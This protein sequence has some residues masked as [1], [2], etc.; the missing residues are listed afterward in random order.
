MPWSETTKMRERMRFVVDAEGDLYTMTELCE[1]YGISRMT[2]HKWLRRFRQDGVGGLEDRSRAPENCPHRTDAEVV[3]ALVDA[4]HRHPNWGARKLILWVAKRQPGLRLPAAS[5]AG[6]ILKRLGLVKDR[7]RRRHLPHPGRPI[8]EGC[9]PNQLWSADFKG[10]FKTRDGVYCYPLT[11]TDSFSRYL[12]GCQSQLSTATIPTKKNFERVFRTYGLPD[13]IRTDNGTPFSAATAISRLS[14]LSVWWIRLGIRPE[15][16]QPSHP[17]QNGRHERM[18]RTLK[19][20]TTRP[21]AANARAQQRVFDSFR[22]EFNSERPHERLAN[23]TPASLYQPSARPYP[24]RL[25]PLEYPGHF[26][27]RR[28]SR[29]GGIRW[30]KGWVNISTSI[31]EENVG[32]E[33]VDDGVWS[34]YFGSLLLG[35]FHEDDLTLHGARLD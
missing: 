30:K 10:Q 28:V 23:Q 7:R 9:S 24:V 27:V 11:V 35:R 8:A 31:I 5:T 12:L 22:E 17:E 4:R 3:N 33:E 13:A 14:R 6:D 1:R 20:E 18:H 32:L 15:L 16:I 21:P 29:N 2:G 34:L 25:P 19:A 26:E